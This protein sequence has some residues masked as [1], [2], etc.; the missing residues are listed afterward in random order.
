MR[1]NAPPHCGHFWGG[2][3]LRVRRSKPTRQSKQTFTVVQD[4]HIILH[5]TSI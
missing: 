1:T 3:V 5:F 4:S 2:G